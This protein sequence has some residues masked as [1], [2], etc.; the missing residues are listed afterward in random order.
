MRRSLAEGRKTASDNVWHR[1]IKVLEGA[2]IR[3][4]NWPFIRV[5]L[6]LVLG[7]VSEKL[8]T[9]ENKTDPISKSELFLRAIVTIKPKFEVKILVRGHWVVGHL[10]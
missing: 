1:V 4:H 10:T 2:T 3:P 6:N 5:L 7:K 9:K 8:K